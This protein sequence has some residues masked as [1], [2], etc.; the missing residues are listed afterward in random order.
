MSICLFFLAPK[1]KRAKTVLSPPSTGPNADW[2][3]AAQ[4]I[5]ETEYQSLLD[6]NGVEGSDGESPIDLSDSIDAALDEDDDDE[7]SVVAAARTRSGRSVK[8]P[9]SRDFI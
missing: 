3:G 2:S 5:I 6:V 7:P 8:K 9:A 1:A 4:P